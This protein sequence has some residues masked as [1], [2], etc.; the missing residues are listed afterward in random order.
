MRKQPASMALVLSGIECVSCQGDNRDFVSNSLIF[1]TASSPPIIGIFIS[2]RMMCRT[3]HC[4][5]SRASTPFFTRVRLYLKRMCCTKEKLLSLSSAI[6]TLKSFL[7]ISLNEGICWMGTGVAGAFSI[8]C[9]SPFLLR[10]YFAGNPCPESGTDAGIGSKAYFSS[11]SF[12]DCSGNGQSQAL[13]LVHSLS[14]WKRAEYSILQFHP[15][16]PRHPN[17]VHA[18]PLFLRFFYTISHFDKPAWVHFTALVRNSSDTC[19]Q[20][21]DVEEIS[22]TRTRIVNKRVS[23]RD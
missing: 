4:V 16:I 23:R 11:S 13:C 18:E 12:Y 7:L 17:P 6:S 15:G 21:V 19:F 9:I 10:I 8:S 5:T 1:R 3:A 14:F 20:T 22:S 2:I